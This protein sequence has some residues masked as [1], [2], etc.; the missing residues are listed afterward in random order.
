M[1]P[2][3]FTIDHA[4]W[5]TNQNRA[6]SR[7]VSTETHAALLDNLLDLGVIQPSKVT[8]WSQVHL[9]RKPN[10]GSSRF[11]IDYRSLNK[12][13]SNEGWQIPNMKEMLVRK[14][15]EGLSASG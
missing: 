12:V 7:R 1:Y 14:K 10:N 5:E 13:I 11:T 6:P 9:V 15:Q 8:A 4:K 2:M 3:D